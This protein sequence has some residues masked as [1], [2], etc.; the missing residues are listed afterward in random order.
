MMSLAKNDGNREVTD[1]DVQLV[2]KRFIKKS[3]KL[4]KKIEGKEGRELV[5]SATE[6]EIKIAETYKEE[7]D[8]Q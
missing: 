1:E 2:L 3:K 5:I 7:V 6:I 4:I 8:G